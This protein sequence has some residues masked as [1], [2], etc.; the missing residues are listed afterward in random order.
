MNL[1]EQHQFVNVI[2]LFLIAVS[3]AECRISLAAQCPPLPVIAN[4][5][6]AYGPDTTPDYDVGTVATYVC[7][8]GFNLFG[9]MTRVC[10]SDRTFSDSPPVCTQRRKLL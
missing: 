3:A 4:G 7:D 10:Q 8:K 9:A 6:I 1:R 2:R 5:M